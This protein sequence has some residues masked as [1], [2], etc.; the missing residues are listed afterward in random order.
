MQQ[1]PAHDALG[2]P[3]TRRRGCLGCFGVGLAVLDSIRRVVFGGIA[4]LILLLLF[5][6]MIPTGTIRVE[7]G[8]AM[9]LG[10]KGVIVEELTGSALERAVSNALGA[11]VMETRL[12]DLIEAVDGAAGDDRI[13]ALVLDLDGMLGGGPSKLAEVG[14]ALARFRDTGKPI[15]ATA[16]FYTRPRYYLAAHATEIHLDDMGAVFLDGYSSFRTY[17][18]EGLEKLGADWNV[19]R[20]GTYKSAVEPYI[21]DDMSPE[22]EAANLEWLG[23]LWSMYLDDVSAARGLDREAL[24]RFADDLAT[25][26][27][28]ADGD[29][30]KAA[31]DVGLVD[32][33][34]GRQTVVARLIELVGE[35]DD[36]GYRNIDHDSYLAA[37]AKNPLADLGDAVGVVVARGTIIPGEAAS[38]TVGGES[39][40]RLLRRA[41]HD[42]T[43]KAVVLRIDSPGGS[44]FASEVIR[45][46]V[47]ALRSAGKP[48][49]V[50]MSSVA[51]SGGYWIAMGADEIWAH[52]QTITGSI[53][54]FSY[55]PTFEQPIAKYLGMRV[56]GVGTTSLAGRIR[57]DLPFPEEAE[58]IMRL[59]LEHGYRQFTG[60]V[61]RSRGMSAEDVEAVAGGRVWSGIDAAE[62]GLV[63]R[64]GGLDDALAS[65]REMAGAESDLPVRYIT[66]RPSAREELLTTFF[67]RTGRLPGLRKA[68][69]SIVL[70]EYAPGTGRAGKLES[71]LRQLFTRELSLLAAAG[72]PNRQLAHCF[73]EIE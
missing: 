54:I 31:L 17:M 2:R 62:A 45:R 24:S 32:A 6:A 12:R 8:V 13:R 71:G 28:A 20:V 15:V 64:L 69:A 14:A 47:E 38:G 23:D 41:R 27:R 37:K 63:D 9:V 48:I 72:D 21:R 58:T 57:P 11:P 34:G 53:G 61:G 52:P 65:A 7:N 10:P 5:V 36:H 18:R 60:L 70:G 50:S 68:A 4:I 66:R 73:C 55:F 46:E 33:V 42:D 29:M 49:V 44:A 40:A 59:G 16:D 22:A 26:L 25:P 56:D 3:T 39:T 1:T 19:M 35:G 43:I 30:A 51:A 67:A